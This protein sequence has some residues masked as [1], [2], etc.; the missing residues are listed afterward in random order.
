MSPLYVCRDLVQRYEGREVLRLPELTVDEG[1]VLALTGPNGCGKSTLLRLLAFLER[2]AS[3]RLHYAGGEDPRQ[4]VTLLL[5][6]AYLLRASVFANV[7][8]GLRLR[9]QRQGLRDIYEECMRAVGF[10]E[11]DELAGRDRRALSGGERQRVAL[12][13]RL[14]LRPRVLLLDEPTSSVDARSGRAIVE[15]VRSCVDRGTTVICATH[16][17]ALMT[18][19]AAREVALGRRW[20]EGEAGAGGEA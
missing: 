12:A 17:R 15:A 18:A 16:D 4:E 9:Q 8:L 10:A 3:G 14:A 5:Q 11:P 20:D 2:P 6:D 7:T 13:A 1:E 19:L